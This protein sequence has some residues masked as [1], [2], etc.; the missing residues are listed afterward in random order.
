M[1]AVSPDT[2]LLSARPSAISH[3]FIPSSLNTT[4]E[5]ILLGH[6]LSYGPE[7]PFSLAILSADA[8]VLIWNAGHALMRDRV[9]RA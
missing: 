2:K 9:T 7:D 1:I 4:L 8:I 3:C 6:N 5:P